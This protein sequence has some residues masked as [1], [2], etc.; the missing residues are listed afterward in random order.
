MA[1]LLHMEPGDIQD[2]IDGLNNSTRCNGCQEIPGFT[3]VPMD[4]G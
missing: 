3:L 4:F 2:V 1:L